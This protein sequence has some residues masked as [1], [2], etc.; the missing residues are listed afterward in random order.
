[1]FAPGEL[2]LRQGEEGD[3]MFIITSGSVDIH[4]IGETGIAEYVATLEA[5]QFFGE[6]SLLTGE[7]RTAN[8]MSMTVVESVRVGKA[9]LADLFEG[10]PET[11][12]EIAGVVA[13]R[14]AELAVT[15]GRLDSEAQRM[16]AAKGKKALLERVQR[17]FGMS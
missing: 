6:M 9:C 1:M 11:A 8:V 5:G 7:K 3:S 10:H 17:Y 14:Q 15:R 13:S 2:V 12:S 4:V 16:M